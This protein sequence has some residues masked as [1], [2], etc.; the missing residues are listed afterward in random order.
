MPCDCVGGDL[1][2]RPDPNKAC[3]VWRLDVDTVADAVLQLMARTE[4]A[5]GAAV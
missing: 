1:C 2:E 3:C 5:L 4:I